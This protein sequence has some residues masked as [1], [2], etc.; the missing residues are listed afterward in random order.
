MFA[1]ARPEAAPMPT[2]PRFPER[3]DFTGS[4]QITRDQLQAI[5]AVNDLF[6]RNLTHS[7]GAWLRSRFDVSLVSAEQMAWSDFTTLVQEPAYICSAA[8][9]PLDAVGALQLDL[10]LAPAIVD[11]LLGGIGHSGP[12][13]EPTEIED[14]ILLSVVSVLVRELNIVWQSVGL[15]FALDKRERDAQIAHLMPD[16]EKV[17]CIS[18][19]AR[20]EAIAGAINL[21]LPSVILS[22]LLRRGTGDRPRRRS[23]ESREHIAQLLAG[24]TFDSA[25]QFSPM[26]LN[27]RA[28]ADLTS[29]SVLALPLPRQAEAQLRVAGLPLFD[30]MPVRLGERRGAQLKSITSSASPEI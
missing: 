10:A 11:V 23:T 27:A 3:Y 26:R 30:A 5:S 1:A 28:L 21:C 20:M 13:R 8:L 19:E 15:A 18:F 2:G 7:L 16:T 22:T 25:L 9:D 4:A 24:I 14:S 29:G 6:A 12:L 17:L